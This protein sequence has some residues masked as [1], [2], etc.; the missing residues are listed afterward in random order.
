MAALTKA[1]AFDPTI[2]LFLIFL[3][4]F[5]SLQFHLT[6]A[7][8]TTGFS[9]KLIHRDSPESPLYPGNLSHYERIKRLVDSSESRVLQLQSIAAAT[10]S[11]SSETPIHPE[12]I[13]PP[14]AR[15]LFLLLVQVNIGTPYKTY[16]LVL[17]TAS[18]LIWIQCDPCKPCFPQKQHKFDPK[19]SPSYHALPCTHT[20]CTGPDYGCVNGQCT[21]TV[22]Y[23]SNGSTKGVLSTET[24]T[25]VTDKRKIEAIDGRIFGCSNANT[26]FHSFL[27]EIDGILGMSPPGDISLI[28]QIKD[29]A[30]RRFSYC[31]PTPS[32][33]SFLRFGDDIVIKPGSKVQ[34]TP[35]VTY[36]S[37][38][39]YA[40]NLTD[41]SVGDDH[42]GM[43]RIGFPPGTFALKQDRTGGC[44][45]DSGSAVTHIDAKPYVELKKAIMGYFQPF[46]LKLIDPKKYEF[47]LCYVRPKGFKSFPSVTFHFQGADLKVVSDFLFFVDVHFFCLVM[48]PRNGLTVLGAMQQTNIRFVYDAGA[49]LLSFVPE[50]CSKDGK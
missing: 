33:T 41:I 40:L 21:Y 8:P 1:L 47:E 27:G 45:I 9:L 2:P 17:D 20:L 46:G 19:K 34:T 23:M 26:G 39:M 30:K 11:I 5:F 25:F 28:A 18:D 12:I 48:K 32:S 38:F 43:V 24:F 14:V 31:L 13:R 10:S 49:G 36:K 35:F 44:I 37:R 15:L 4:C 16:Y 42:S 3:F 6:I 50:D 7:K 29:V 22:E